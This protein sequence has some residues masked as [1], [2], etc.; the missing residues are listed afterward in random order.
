MRATRA[1]GK[2][3]LPVGLLLLA[4]KCYTWRKTSLSLP[5]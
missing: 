1:A 4:D 2:Q 5:H 3:C